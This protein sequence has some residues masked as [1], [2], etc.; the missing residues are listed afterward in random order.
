M[1]PYTFLNYAAF[2]DELLSAMDA[3]LYKELRIELKE[4]LNSVRVT[5]IL[6]AHNR[7]SHEPR[8]YID[9]HRVE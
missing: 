3:K 5:T 4:I 9:G 7:K 1:P 6:I 8:R 2:I